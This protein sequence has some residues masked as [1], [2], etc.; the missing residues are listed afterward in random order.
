MADGG[1]VSP[2]LAE[3]IQQEQAK[4]QVRRR[5]AIGLA[6]AAAFFCVFCSLPMLP[7]VLTA[8]NPAGDRTGDALELGAC[9]SHIP[10]CVA[11]CARLGLRLSL[12]LAPSCPRNVKRGGAPLPP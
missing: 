10:A 4:A 9:L 11:T 7:A 8:I 2:Q 5:V 12:L 3:F 6:S 1:K